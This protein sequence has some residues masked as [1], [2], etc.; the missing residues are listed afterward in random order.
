MA[1]RDGRRYTAARRWSNPGGRIP[2]NRTCVQ[3]AG[4]RATREDV[5][6][7]PGPMHPV[8]R[9]L[10]IAVLS[11]AAAPAAPASAATV[12]CIDL[13][14][15]RAGDCDKGSGGGADAPR[16]E[17]GA[18]PD[19]DLLPD[20]GNLTLIRRSTLC[21]LNGER[22][23]RGLK[24]LRDQRTLRGVATRYAR[25]MVRDRF[26]AHEA[27][28]GSTMTS[29]I[30]KSSYLRRARAWSIGENLAW[31]AGDRSTP[32][33]IVRAWMDSP[34]HRRN[35]LDGTFR[36]IGVGITIGAPAEVRAASPAATFVTEF[37]RRR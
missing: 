20:R 12:P 6:A 9:A 37:G 10:L 36:D 21:L 3:R 35:I 29:R 24:P 28:G 2:C 31:G 25:Q 22:A 5:Q 33:R 8:R 32:G 26:F 11:L 18:C 15:V 14:L 23:S 7:D 13:G 16:A 27:P 19:V 4:A 34:G 17:G 30:R 1:S